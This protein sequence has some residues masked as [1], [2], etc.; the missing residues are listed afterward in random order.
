MLLSAVLSAVA[1][2]FTKFSYVYVSPL[3]FGFYLA[4]GL[5]LLYTPTLARCGLPHVSTEVRMPWFAASASW[6]FLR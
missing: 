6:G 2:T 4:L 1:V 5:F 3:Q